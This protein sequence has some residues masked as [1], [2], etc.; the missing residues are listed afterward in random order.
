MT[1]RRG[2]SETGALVAFG[3][4]RNAVFKNRTNKLMQTP[5][6]KRDQDL[7]G[8]RT[9][10]LKRKGHKGPQ[11]SPKVTSALCAWR[12]LRDLRVESSVR[13]RPTS[14]GAAAGF[15]KIE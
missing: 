3:I 10:A 1:P 11:K 13:A 8:N 14:G 9:E 6:L 2:R 5:K 12:L 15:S 7:V 4:D